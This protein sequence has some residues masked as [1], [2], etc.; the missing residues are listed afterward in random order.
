MSNGPDGLQFVHIHPWEEWWRWAERG[1]TSTVLEKA[2]HE[3]TRGGKQITR[4]LT[5][6]LGHGV[7]LDIHEG[8]RMSEL[9]KFPLEEH[10]IVTVSLF[11]S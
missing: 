9:Y 6:S 4:G 5:H 3:T 10:N 1:R 8:P 2:G 7:G 11:S